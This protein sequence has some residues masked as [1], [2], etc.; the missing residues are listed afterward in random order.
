MLG[1]A[2]KSDKRPICRFNPSYKA[3]RCPTKFTPHE[4]KRI[5]AYRSIKHQAWLAGPTLKIVTIAQ[6]IGLEIRPR[7]RWGSSCLSHPIRPV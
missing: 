1:I 5:A 4:G 2:N 3:R 7:I 6:S